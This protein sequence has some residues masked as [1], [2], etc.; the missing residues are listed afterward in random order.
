MY[1][2]MHMITVNEIRG[3]EFERVGGVDESIWRE[4]GGGE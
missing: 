4:E 2:Y 1:S 3:H